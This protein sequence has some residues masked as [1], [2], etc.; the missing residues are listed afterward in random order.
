M[1]NIACFKQFSSQFL[2]FLCKAK[3][4]LCYTPESPSVV[5]VWVSVHICVRVREQFN[6]CE[7]FA[8]SSFLT[9]YKGES[10]ETR[11]THTSAHDHLNTCTIHDLDLHVM[12]Y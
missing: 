2:V 12:V 1:G 11:Y 5:G 8:F 3:T 9:M 6:L 10:N 7:L 4:S